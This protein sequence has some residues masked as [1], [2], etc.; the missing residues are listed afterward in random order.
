MT[1]ILL[2]MLITIC[3]LGLFAYVTAFEIFKSPT[4]LSG[5]QLKEV[6]LDTARDSHARWLLVEVSSEGFQ[7]HLEYPI[8]RYKFFVRRGEIV[9]QTNIQRL[10]VV[11]HGNEIALATDPEHSFK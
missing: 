7:L 10:P 4:P 8:K 2:G 1:K 6:W 11:I 3:V 9:L 5:E